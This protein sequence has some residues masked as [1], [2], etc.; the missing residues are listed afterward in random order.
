MNFLTR[1]IF[2]SFLALGVMG[3]DDL[4]MMLASAAISAGAKKASEPPGMTIP[5]QSPADKP[6]DLNAL[7]SQAQQKKD[8]SGIGLEHLKLT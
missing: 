4:L 7:V 3:W 2:P 5:G 8:D 1:L 6:M